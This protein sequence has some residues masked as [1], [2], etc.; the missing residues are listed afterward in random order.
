MLFEGIRGYRLVTGVELVCE[1]EAVLTLDSGYFPYDT[2][3]VC[4][5]SALE[6]ASKTV[7]L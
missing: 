3:V 6:K 4:A 7:F 1:E 2:R 5:D